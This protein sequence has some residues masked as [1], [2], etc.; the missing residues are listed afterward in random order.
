MKR[1][2]SALLA[3]SRATIGGAFWLATRSFH[4]VEVHGLEYDSRAPHTYYGM[5]HKRD[6]DPIILIPTVVFHRGWRGL[7]GDVHFALRGDGFEP[8][9]L[10]RLV[11]YPR[12]V[13]HA[14]HLL[15]VGSALRWLGAHPTDDL[16]RP[17]EEWIRELLSLG[18]HGPT[19]D[20]FSPDFIEEIATA[21]GEPYR[22]LEAYSLSKLLD[23]RYQHALQHFYGPEIL[24]G[25]VRRSLERQAVAR[26]KEHLADL[27]VC[28]WSGGSLFGSPEG[29]L[30]PDGK[31]SPINSGVH[32][33]LRAAPPD[34]RIVPI[35]TIYDFM[36]VGR[37]H[38]FIDFAPAIEH[39]PALSPNEFDT[40]LRLAWLQSARF[41][42]TQLA[43]GFLVQAHRAGLSSFTLDDL[44]D[45]LHHRATT[46]AAADR[47][48]DQ[49]LLKLHGA[50][51]R[52]THFLA[53]AVRYG[54]VRHTGN[55]SWVPTVTETIIKVRPREV[56][57][58]QLPL[59][60]A[61]NELQEMLS[62]QMIDVSPV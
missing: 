53:Y 44:A 2:E 12:W 6:L 27:D 10:A 60:Y 5:A 55:H 17:A 35:F 29:Q 59:M 26:I 32:R 1:L 28:L 31:L 54:L 14:L 22:K 23:W 9:Y 40:Q 45:D 57:Y 20:V 16:L 37:I 38:V 49:Q 19:G 48:V 62:I 51:K 30:S 50:C 36:R 7:G 46:L 39:A 8:G 34:T 42:C 24:V 58:D 3:F 47:H 21:T 11:M 56:G 33:I 52:A 41:T 4:H 15:P 61:W 43:S 18:N 25:N 13:S